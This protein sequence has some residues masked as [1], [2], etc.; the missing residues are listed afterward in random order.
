MK[1]DTEIQKKYDTLV[2]RHLQ[3][4][5]GKYCKIRPS[6]CTW[7]VEHV[8]GTD[9]V[10]VCTCLSVETETCDKI[11]QA[12]SCPHYTPQ[13]TREEVETKFL[14]EISHQ[15]T[16]QDEYRDLYMLQWALEPSNEPPVVD[17]VLWVPYTLIPYQETLYKRALNWFWYIYISLMILLPNRYGVPKYG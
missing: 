12:E 3:R 2:K 6:N 10:R 11:A 4:K 9:S 16:L 15:V 8:V 7:N 17:P 1:S 14:S 5:V 13:L